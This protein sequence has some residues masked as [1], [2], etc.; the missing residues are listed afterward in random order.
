MDFRSPRRLLPGI[1]DFYNRKGWFRQEQRKRRSYSKKWYEMK[2]M[3][4]PRS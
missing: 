3:V 2:E 1:Q 4:T